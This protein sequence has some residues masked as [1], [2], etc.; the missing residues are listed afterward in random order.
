MNIKIESLGWKEKLSSGWRVVM[1]IMITKDQDD[2]I[3]M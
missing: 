2:K 3:L 1:V